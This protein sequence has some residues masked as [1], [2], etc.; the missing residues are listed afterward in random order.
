VGTVLG[1]ILETKESRPLNE[2]E[3]YS[4]IRSLS[5][6]TCGRDFDPDEHAQTCPACGPLL[7][8]LDVLYDLQPL[9]GGFTPD[10]LRPRPESTLWRYHE[11]LPIRDSGRLAG[12][13]V[14][15]TPL[16]RLPRALAPDV[17]A[18]LYVKDDTRMPSASSK[19]RATAVALAHAR[20]IGA[21]AVAA[22]STGNAA[23][24]LAALAAGAGL[25]VCLFAPASAPPVKLAQIRVHGAALFA[26]EGT[27]DE[28][29]DLCG[30]VCERLGF[31]NRNTAVNPYLG[32]GKKTLALE[33]W[34]Q[35]GYRAPA[36]VVIP[37]GDGCIL[38]G[39][40]KGFRD[41]ADLGLIERVPRLIGAQ[42]EG[43]A[44]LAQAW[45][46]GA[47]HCT[48]VVAAT[49]ADS[50]CVGMPRDQI[51]AL[52]AVRATQGAFVTMSDKAILEALAMLARGAGI[53]VEPAAAAALA[54]WREAVAS[55]VLSSDE[56]AVLLLTGHGLKD[57]AA[58]ERAAAGNVPYRVRP[59]LEAVLALL[60][61]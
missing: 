25:P 6:V 9:R 4:Y 53:F 61:R 40:Y 16:Y 5:C 2:H 22:A 57:I 10:G 20:E 55:G 43:S 7:G 37:V 12:I 19:D 1:I 29:F 36:A 38:G 24:S 44:A 45:R 27:Y 35:L 31:Y 41:L 56:E 50:L 52:R 21:P 17:P 54:G 13:P 33:I 59:D 42:A 15:M 14:G 18:G 3:R 58:A 60:R 11:L 28:A 32:E 46:A 8:T 39:V 47:D 23:A 34:E 49:V 48:P 26:I 51:K 30:A